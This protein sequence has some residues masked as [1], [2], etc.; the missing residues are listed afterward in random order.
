MF[1]SQCVHDYEA[2]VSMAWE[3]AREVARA[4]QQRRAK[5]EAQTRH[6]SPKVTSTPLPR[7]FARLS[8]QPTASTTLK[9][10]VKASSKCFTCGQIGHFS[11]ECPQAPAEHKALEELGY[12]EEDASGYNENQEPLSEPESENE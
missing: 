5:Q 8:V 12:E 6:S 1:R 11:R 7:A 9:P 3:Q 4:D 2:Y 10:A